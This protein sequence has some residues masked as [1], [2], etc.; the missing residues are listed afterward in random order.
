[1]LPE[2]AME[3]TICVI[4]NQP[5]IHLG[6]RQNEI[7]VTKLGKFLP[8]FSR[9]EHQVFEGW[10]CVTCSSQQ[11]EE[12]VV[13]SYKSELYCPSCKNADEYIYCEIIGVKPRT[14]FGPPM[15][16]MEPEYYLDGVF[17]D[18]DAVSF[19]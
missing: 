16:A 11:I 6:R 4:E 9:C 5:H 13:G 3:E 2:G 17:G 19:K 10:C 12:K 18:L 7:F 14:S 15:N 8:L 1:M